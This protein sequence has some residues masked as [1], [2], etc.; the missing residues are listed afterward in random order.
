[1]LNLLTSKGLFW[2]IYV[3]SVGYTGGD[4]VKKPLTFYYEGRGVM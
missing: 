2:I 1:M 3:E 4:G